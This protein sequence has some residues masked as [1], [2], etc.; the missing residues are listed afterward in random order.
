MLKKLLIA[1]FGI[2][3]PLG[4][5]IIVFIGYNFVFDSNVTLEGDREF[6]V[7]VLNQDNPLDIYNKLVG[8][9][10]LK[11]E[12]S[13]KMVAQQKKWSVA[14]SGRYI[15]KS[16]MNNNDLVNMFRAGLQ[17]PVLVTINQV[18]SVSDVAGQASKQLMNDSVAFFSVFVNEDFLAA[19]KLDYASV[20]S[21][22]L[23]NTYEFYW[24]TSVVD[25]RERIVKEYEAFWNEERRGQ[26]N[27]KG[28]NPLKVSILASIVEKET[29]NYDEMPVVAGLYLNRLKKGMLLQSDPTVIYAKKLKEGMDIEIT[30]VLYADL[31]IDS[32][33]N[34]YKYAGLPPA[35]ITIPSLQAI[36]AVLNAQN[37]KYIFMC[38]D[39]DRPGYHSFAVNL[40]QHNVNKQ[41][42]VKWLNDN[43]IMR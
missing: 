15:V 13:F 34:T 39:P 30:R 33:Y 42:Y 18:A 19:T 17:E 37:H 8:A 29:A 14:K 5:I 7:F 36:N 24:N 4:L 27:A 26:A 16:G 23:P 12:S 31:E 2:L 21:I 41:K 35:P 22:I 28:L 1:I 20:R 6:E 3:L 10:I 9:G 11:N 43:K 25:F 40:S 38:A 32:P